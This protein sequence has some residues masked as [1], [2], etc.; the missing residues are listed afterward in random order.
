M[1]PSLGRFRY[2]PVSY[3]KAGAR[4]L[5]RFYPQGALWLSPERSATMGSGPGTP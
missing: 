1:A 3:R 4:F 5:L 2:G